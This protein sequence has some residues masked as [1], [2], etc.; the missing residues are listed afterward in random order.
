MA[1][2]LSTGLRQ[3]LL[4]TADF[5][6]EFT[7]CFINIYTGNQPADP[8]DAATGTLLA[9]LYSNRRIDGRFVVEVLDRVTESEFATI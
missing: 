1:L 3:A 6:T 2:R 8:D 5:R 7:G 9:K 4:G